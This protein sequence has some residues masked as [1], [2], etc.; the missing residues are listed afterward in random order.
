MVWDSD[1]MALFKTSPLRFVLRP[2]QFLVIRIACWDVLV[3]ALKVN[4]GID[5]E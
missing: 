2:M 4:D 3:Q 5:D 1:W